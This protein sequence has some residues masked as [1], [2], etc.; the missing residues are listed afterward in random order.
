MINLL[1]LLATPLDAKAPQDGVA[2]ICREIVSMAYDEFSD[3]KN[4][5]LYIKG[6]NKT[7]DDLIDKLG[8][9]IDD[10]ATAWWDIVD[11]FFKHNYIHEA[12]LAQRYAVPTLGDLAGFSKR[13]RITNMYKLKTT[14]SEQ[15]SDF[16]FRSL[17]DGIK[18]YPILS[19]P[20]KF[21]L[22]EAQ[23]IS[24]DLD[25]VAKRGGPR[26]DRITGV[27]YMLA[28]HIVGSKFFMMP[29]DVNLVGNLYQNYHRE[30]IENLR[31]DP[32]R[33]CYDEFHRAVRSSSVVADQIIGDLETSSRESRKWNLHIGLYSQTMTDIPDIIIE[34]STAIY[35]L[36]AGTAK[37]VETT[38]QRLGLNQTAYNAIY[39][40]KKPGKQ[41]ASMV[42]IFKTSDGL[43]VQLLTNTVGMQ[44]LWAFSSTTEDVH[45]RN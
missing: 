25:E 34:L 44:A 16:V 28:R 4:P 43:A 30:R 31:Q 23:I 24:L 6:K 11:E 10:K 26:E 29:E 20:T 32:K 15:V 17:L 5:K 41:G 33:L 19:Q 39:R 22:G 27:M 40:L 13:D 36:G 21:D 9:W 8:I 18:D 38:V 2:G 3:E 35:V 37:S 45:L 1:T 42:A 12:T 14:T 7:I